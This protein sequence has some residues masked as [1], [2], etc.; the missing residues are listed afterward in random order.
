MT[1]REN[2]ALCGIVALSTILLFGANDA[3]AR[4]AAVSQA[5][6]P[7]TTSKPRCSGVTIGG[8]G[9]STATDGPEIATGFASKDPAFTRTLMAVTANPVASRA[10]WT[11]S[12]RESSPPA[13]AA[14]A[15]AAAAPNL[16]AP[17][18]TAASYAKI[19]AQ[20]DKIL[21]T[22]GEIADA[23]DRTANL[24]GVTTC[25]GL[26][27]A[28][29]FGGILLA[30]RRAA[31]ASIAAAR[32]LPTLERA[33][34]FLGKQIALTPPESLGPSAAVSLVFHASFTNHGRTPAVVRWINLDHH[35]L[36]ERPSGAYEDH[37]RHGVGL[38]IGA[39]ETLAVADS[40]LT[41]P[42]SEW[43]RAQA[44]DG[45]IYL[46]GRIVYRDIFAAQHET[47]FCWRYDIPSRA[48]VVVESEALNRYD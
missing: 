18:P 24:L 6:V 17:E 26:V 48:F 11:A 1:A 2:S 9:R 39:G 40:P 14:G 47:Y 31:R 23:L 36:A 5:T 21:D 10:A 38:V 16:P 15:P 29:L 45:A 28:L 13:A 37:E 3:V 30:I 33:Y 22:E 7:A 42:R 41:I 27:L 4:P 34:V 12:V 35:Y 32:A 44:G 25:I 46:D 19:Q 20:N 8:S 43:Q